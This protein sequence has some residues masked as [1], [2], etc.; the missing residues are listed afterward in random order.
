MPP[1][2]KAAAEFGISFRRFADDDLPF[3]TD[4]YASTR[5][6]EIAVTGWPADVQEQFLAHQ[7]AAQHSHYSIH[8]ADA[9]W[10]IIERDGEPIGRLYLRETADDLNIIDI[11]LL[12]AS[13]GQGIG[14]AVLEDVLDQAR[15]LGRGVT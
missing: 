10:L 5:R 12:P 15:G 13:R 1:P 7:A 2:L 9:E 3:V 6:E 11:A 8:F 4:L 14:G